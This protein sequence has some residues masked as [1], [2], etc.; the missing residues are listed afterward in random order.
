VSATPGREKSKYGGEGP[1]FNIGGLGLEERVQK[2]L[3]EAARHSIARKTWATYSTAERL[4]QRF[5]SE[6]KQVLEYPVSEQMM[7]NFIHW[8]AYD[9]NVSAATINGYLAGV[10]KIHIVRGWPE[11]QLRTQL[12]KMVLEGRKNM[13]AADRLRRREEGRQPVTVDIMKVIKNRLVEWEAES[14]DKLSVW[15]VCTLLFHGVLR[16]GELLC[17][18]T[19][20]FDP[21]C[22]LT[23]QDILVV[24][25][26]KEAGK[27]MVQIKVKMPKEDKKGEVTV[28]D[29]YENGSDICPVRAVRKWQKATRGAEE[30]QPAFRFASGVPITGA[31]FNA[32]L[33]ARLDGWLE[34]KI[35]AHSFRI[36]A[37]SRMGQAGLADS[38][39]QA[40]GRWGSRAFETY[41]RLPRTKRMMVA[42]RMSLLK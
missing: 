31:G 18:S 8:L 7:L 17:R 32:V 15:A 30:D 34:E 5:C 27:S 41:L 38:E 10:R 42:R 22:S 12:V 25:D 33:K 29:I 1:K 21:A 14:A 26:R 36:G 40:V 11:P 4:L 13:E 35:T 20:M 37:A 19:F 9:R 16:G 6:K 39:V 28:V 3:E 2:D 23:R 24:E